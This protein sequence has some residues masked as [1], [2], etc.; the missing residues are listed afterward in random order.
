[1]ANVLIVGIVLSMLAAT[2]NSL[3]AVPSAVVPITGSTTGGSPAGAPAGSVMATSGGI[4]SQIGLSGPMMTTPEIFSPG[5]MAATNALSSN[6]AI[7]GPA[8]S[9]PHRPAAGTALAAVADP[10]IPT[11]SCQPASAGCDAVSGNSGGAVAQRLGLS[12][13]V[14]DALYPTIGDIEPPDQGLCAGN[15]YVMEIINIGTLQ[16]FKGPP[17]GLGVASSTIPLDSLMGLTTLGWSSAGDISCV[18]DQSHG[19][20]WIVTEFVS[21]SPESAGGPFAGCFAGVADTCLEGIAVSVNENPLGTYNVYFLNPNAVN[22]DPG[23]GYLLNDFT[24]IATTRDAFLLFYDEFNL[25]GSTIPACPAFG[26]G[27]FNGAQEFAFSKMAL[28]LG[29]S[30]TSPRFT[31]AYVNMG[32]LP[33]P[34]GFCGLN[35]ENPYTCWYEVIPAQSSNPDQWDNHWGG[36]GFMAAS[37]DFFGVGDTRVAVFYWTGLSAL[38]SVECRECSHIGFGGQLFTNV[39]PY[40]DDG[41]ACP[42]S[43]GTPCGLAAQKAGPVPLA[44]NCANPEFYNYIGWT[45]SPGVTTCT[46]QGI[47]TNGDSATQASLGEGQVWFALSTLV[48]QTFGKSSEIHVGGAFYVIGTASFDAFGILSLT[49]DGYVTAAHEE[50]EFPTIAA[51]NDPSQGALVSF[52]LSGDGGPMHVHNG[53][54]FPSSAYGVLTATSGGLV[55]GT[56]HITALGKAPQ[57]GF[58]EYQFFGTSGERPRWGDYGAAVFVPGTGFYFASEY[59]QYPNCGAAHFLKD[60]TCGGTRDPDANFGTSIGWLPVSGGSGG[61]GGGVI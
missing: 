8:P 31:Y 50:I 33:T 23:K 59:I 10:P 48:D 4:A 37:L 30:V 15:N 25:N 36:T 53:G 17:G 20:H 24:K 42:A 58:S 19:G 32:L 41:A 44:V 45:L 28:E 14:N 1:M 3:A 2:G 21:A 55:R 39:A 12:A 27:G 52:T 11:V 51:A 49:S 35:T 38:N 6:A 61:G 7:H 34:D 18:Y 29:L 60:P 56:I 40:T 22:N 43:F 9:L 13:R 47:A 5:T 54:Y 46:E 57:D 26:C 16:V